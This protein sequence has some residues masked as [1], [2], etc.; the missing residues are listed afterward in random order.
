M[1]PT[2]RLFAGDN[3]KA[4]EVKIGTLTLYF[5]YS[6]IVAFRKCGRLVVHKNVGSNTTGRHIANIPGSKDVQH[7]SAEDFDRELSAVTATLTE[8]DAVPEEEPATV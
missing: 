5:S 8:G 3:I 1:I 2:L 6:T 7:L 4:Y